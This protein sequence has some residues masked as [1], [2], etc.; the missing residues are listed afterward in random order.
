MDFP[1]MDFPAM[2][3]KEVWQMLHRLEGEVVSTFASRKRHRY[4]IV[5]V[6][7]DGVVRQ[8]EGS[9]ERKPESRESMVGKLHFQRTWDRLAHVGVCG[10]ETR[11]AGFVAACV[12]LPVRSRFRSS[13]M[14]FPAA[15]VWVLSSFVGTLPW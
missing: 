12:Q 15:W 11:H 9:A 13:R 6:L 7:P 8:A 1:A 4:R 5:K 14:P 10:M 2:D 3:F